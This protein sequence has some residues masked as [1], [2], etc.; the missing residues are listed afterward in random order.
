M[1]NSTLGSREI[2]DSQKGLRNL[3]PESWASIFSASW[4]VAGFPSTFQTEQVME[5]HMDVQVM[6]PH[7]FTDL[8]C[9]LVSQRGLPEHLRD[10]GGGYHTGVPRS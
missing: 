2:N 3:L 7:V 9:L 10:N 4:A 5:P 8:L 6:G 1:Y